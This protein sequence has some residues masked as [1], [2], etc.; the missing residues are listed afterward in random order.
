MF[1]N[2]EQKMLGVLL[3]GKSLGSTRNEMHRGMQ[4]GGF[5]CLPNLIDFL[6]TSIFSSKIQFV[7]MSKRKQVQSSLKFFLW[8][9]ARSRNQHKPTMPAEALT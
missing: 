9:K 8:R 6:V 5:S 4:Y 7:E 2:G 3:A 1:R